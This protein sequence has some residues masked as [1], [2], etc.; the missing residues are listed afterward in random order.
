MTLT[1]VIDG[2]GVNIYCIGHAFVLEI[3]LFKKVMLVA[4]HQCFLRD[5]VISNQKHISYKRHFNSSS[6]TFIW[7][8]AA[9]VK[10]ENF[11]YS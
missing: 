8:V 4:F 10:R 3:I 1:F 7:I 11:S 5:S 9:Y 2:E 6:N